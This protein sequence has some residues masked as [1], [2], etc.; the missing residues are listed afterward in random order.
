MGFCK[1]QWTERTKVLREVFD[2][3]PDR[4]ENVFWVC[5]L[6]LRIDEVGEG[7]GGRRG[8]RAHGP[9]REDAA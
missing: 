6:C 9:G 2:S 4:R 3:V 5:R 8:G 1:H 7:P